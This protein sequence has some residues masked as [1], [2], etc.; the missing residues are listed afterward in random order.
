MLENCAIFPGVAQK[1]AVFLLSRMPRGWLSFCVWL[2]AVFAARRAAASAA[3][4]RAAARANPLHECALRR[5][6]RNRAHRSVNLQ[7][8]QVSR[9]DERSKLLKGS[10]G[11]ENRPQLVKGQAFF[12]QREQRTCDTV[13]AGSAVCMAKNA[14]DRR[15][16]RSE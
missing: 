12:G 13:R 15:Y 5:V 1:S 8:L 16:E 2:T 10:A 9:A 4:L 11:G 7:V 14:K 6:Q 3:V